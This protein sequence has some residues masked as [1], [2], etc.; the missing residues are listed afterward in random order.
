MKR[1]IKNLK[2]KI[3][4]ELENDLNLNFKP[5]NFIL[6]TRYKGKC[7]RSNLIPNLRKLTPTKIEFIID[8]IL[9]LNL[10][11]NKITTC[12]NCSLAI[13]THFSACTTVKPMH[14]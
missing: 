4:F 8:R 3:T 9:D 6:Q 2:I 5:C 10:G 13:S 1:V 12:W 7:A 14:L 11:R